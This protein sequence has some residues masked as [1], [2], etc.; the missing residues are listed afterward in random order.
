MARNSEDE[1]LYSAFALFLKNCILEDGSLL[2]KGQNIWTMEMLQTFKRLFYD[3]PNLSEELDFFEKI[4][5]QLQSAPKEIWGLLADFFYIYYLPAKKINYDLKI[6]N[7]SDCVQK[8]GLSLYFDQSLLETLKNGFC[9]TGQQYNLKYR[10]FTFL[11]LFAINLKKS[12]KT[13]T[14]LQDRERYQKLAQQTLE[15]IPQKDRGYD[16]YQAILYLSFPDYYEDI[17]S[18]GDKKKIV[19]F[20]ADKV[21]ISLTGDEDAKLYAIRKELNR[22]HNVSEGFS[23]YEA[24][25]KRLWKDSPSKKVIKPPKKTI[26]ED[27]SSNNEVVEGK[28][29]FE[30]TQNL[31]LYGPPGTGKTFMA[32]KIS[33]EMVA[34][35]IK[36][37]ADESKYYKVI[38]PLRFFEILG[39]S[40]YQNGKDK[41][42]SVGEI[43]QQKVVRAKYTFSPVQKENENIWSTLQSHTDPENQY[44]KVQNRYE[45][46]LFSKNEKSQWSLTDAGVEYIEQNYA[47][48]LKEL[49]APTTKW[50]ER[51]FIDWI[52]FHQS[53]TY[54]EFVE[55]LR[56]LPPDIEG[57]E[58]IVDI[59]PG[60]FKE[61]CKNAAALPN[62][63][64]ILIIDE[65]NRGNISKI[66]G[67]LITLIEDDKRGTEY[68]VTLP[69]SK[70]KFSVPP[71]LYIIG[72]MNS[73]DRSIALLD[74][75]LRRRFSFLE[76]IPKPF[77]LKD[78]V[79]SYGD[80]S[81]NLGEL[82]HGLNLRIQK[83]IDRDHRIGHSYFLKIL[84]SDKDPKG[85]FEHAWNYQIVPLL[86][87]YFSSQPDKL[88]ELLPSFFKG[89]DKDEFEVCHIP[90][91]TDEDLLE[92][93]IELSTPLSNV[94]E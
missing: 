35:Q 21:N 50:E 25:F 31:I 60:V 16:I 88:K 63:C 74:I 24:D 84:S 59:V 42:F 22:T 76:I 79:I 18:K 40:I 6:K 4:N 57:G 78:V 11:L 56:P 80:Y 33:K 26:E 43:R 15:E 51:D 89:N 82:L 32:R 77:L 53:Y 93:L 7:I 48:I 2:L 54:E 70:E 62:K 10:Q 46:F 58:V 41:A 55:G 3:S 61:K 87:E 71:N 27:E 85:V 94:E 44:V 36:A 81:V 91:L 19:E 9:T 65:I 37:D 17:I 8:S 29:V 75:A 72:T 20:Y 38:A 49:K 47:D 86:E 39:I 5:I 28:K 90:R 67:E 73:T 69:Y 83:L 14:I 34:E 12:A 92:S 68:E 1:K 23:F 52:T 45:P 30:Y 13:S 64:H 66:F